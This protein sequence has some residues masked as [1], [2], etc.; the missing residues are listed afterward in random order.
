MLWTFFTFF[1][2]SS[3]HSSSQ[4]DKRGRTFSYS[5]HF[6]KH[7]SPNPGRRADTASAPPGRCSLSSCF[8][9]THF[10]GIVLMPKQN[11]DKWQN[12]KNCY[13]PGVIL[14]SA[15]LIP[16]FLENS[17]TSYS[18]SEGA[19]LIWKHKLHTRLTTRYPKM[20][21]DEQSVSVFLKADELQ[22]APKLCKGFLLQ[23]IIQCSY[24]E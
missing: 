22:A 12:Y 5:A 4:G 21:L 13:K 15:L 17:S 11:K 23:I 9:D 6:T 8:T 14:W 19:N 7:A 2:S 10:T 18:T 1:P 24:P 3:A 20:R 16:D